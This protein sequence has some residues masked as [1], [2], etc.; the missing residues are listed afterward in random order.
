MKKIA[1]QFFLITLTLFSILTLNGQNV[2]PILPIDSVTGK[3]TYTKVVYVDSLANKQVLFSKAR[4]WFAKAYISSTNVIQMED[5]ESGKII[6]KAKIQV[7]TKGLF[8]GNYPA[9]FI[10]YTISIFV[11]DYRYKYEITNFY[12]TG[13]DY[14]PDYGNCENMINSTAPEKKVY[15]QLLYQMDNNIKALIE[16]LTSAM[17]SKDTNLK[18][19]DW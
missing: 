16:D 6:G 1:Q 3:I 13:Q 5:K 2:T 18:K 14:T 17:N 7:Y 10:N 11:K 12:H 4:E 9:G 8:G 19:D 15:T